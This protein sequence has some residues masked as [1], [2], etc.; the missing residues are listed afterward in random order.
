MLDFLIKYDDKIISRILQLD[1]KKKCILAL[2]EIKRQEKVIT[3]FDKTYKQNLCIVFDEYVKVGINLIKNVDRVNIFNIT[4][5]L[6]NFIPDTNDYGEIEGVFAQNGIISLM[7]FFEFYNSDDDINFMRS[8]SKVIE[9]VDSENYDK[10]SDYNEEK[11]MKNE[12]KILSDF[13]KILKS[14]KTIDELIRLCD[15]VV[16]ENYVI[17]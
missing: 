16:V 3:L 1:K 8:I 6:E 10:N 11:I 7:Y 4:S 14:N 15:E 13:S 17:W 12:L 9:T 2:S 5:T